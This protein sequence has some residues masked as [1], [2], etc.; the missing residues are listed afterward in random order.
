MVSEIVKG[1]I[2]TTGR[3]GIAPAVVNSLKLDWNQS[4]YAASYNIY[5]DTDP[6]SAGGVDGLTD[7]WQLLG[8]TTETEYIHSNGSPVP[9]NNHSAFSYVV[10]SIINLAADTYES[11]NSN[12]MYYCGQDFTEFDK[13]TGK[14]LGQWGYSMQNGNPLLN[15][16]E[17]FGYSGRGFSFE[18]DF[19]GLSYSVWLIL[20]T[21]Y[22]PEIPTATKAYLEFNHRHENFASANGYFVGYTTEGLPVP[23][24]N[25]VEG[26]IHVDSV[27]DGAGYNDYYSPAIMNE[28]GYPIS[29]IHNFQKSGGGYWGWYFSK[30]NLSDAIEDGGDC[31]GI[32]GMAFSEVAGN[33]RF[34]LDDCAL[35][36]Y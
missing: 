35:I 28:F 32:L 24:N 13:H 14:G 2:P 1:V 18:N 16:I 5:V 31:Y 25:V 6:F 11:K 22:I 20:K 8:N 4:L 9:F 7:G 10:R 12:L 19:N 21:P 34:E 36:V 27:A 26:V 17:D 23:Y 29:Y 33:H 30:F 3:S 15:D